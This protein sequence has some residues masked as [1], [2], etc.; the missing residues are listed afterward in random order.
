MLRTLRVVLLFAPLLA[1]LVPMLT[2]RTG[3]A[4]PLWSRK[5]ELKCT[6]CHLAFPR[7]NDFGMKFKQ[8]GYRMKDEDGESPWEAKE[9]PF[10]AIVNVG[11]AWDRIDTLDTSTNQRGS[12]TESGFKRNAVE[13]HA[14]GT[15]APRVSFHVDADFSNDT[16][17]L[18]AG[19]AFV[20]LDDLVKGGAL[21][22]K[23]GVYDAD[24]PY[25]ASSRT[26]TLADYLSPVTLDATG[27]ELN[28]TSSK[29]TYAAG[30]INSS[31]DRLNG[32]PTSS[33]FNQLE[34]V[35]AWLMHDFR[36][37]LVAARIY[38][39]QQ[40]PRK[41][42]A[43]SSQHLQAEISAYLNRARW[44]VIPGYTYQ[45]FDD[46]PAVGVTDK[47]HT[48]L[49]E[50]LAWLDKASRWALTARW[51]LEHI[52]KNSAAA[53]QDNQLEAVDLGYYWNPNLKLALDWTHTGDNVGGEKLDEIQ[54]LAH[55]GF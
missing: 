10:S 45:Q 53:V 31:R 44:F 5:Y 14:A 26:T 55:L 25:L 34:N 8:N 41:P 40:D 42:S 21:N 15:L 7:L 48:T 47:H 4:L 46:Q 49:L 16:D 12:R 33:S 52:E 43:S 24:I 1:L 36:G 11:A 3:G 35:Y 19:T 54:V 2:P 37:Q 27:I 38:L 39:D 20:Q 6:D 32:S 51:E 9:F 22:L 17:N 30:L 13:F 23:G 28:G 29:W 18:E 50:G